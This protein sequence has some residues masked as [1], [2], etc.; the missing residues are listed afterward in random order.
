MRTQLLIIRLT[1]P[2]FCLTQISF[3]QDSA[4]QLVQAIRENRTEEVVRLVKNGS[5]VNEL[6]KIG[7]SPCINYTIVTNSEIY[8]DNFTINILG[9]NIPKICLT[10]CGPASAT[11]PITNIQNKTYDIE[12]KVGNNISTGR[13]YCKSNEFK[14]QMNNLIQTKIID[15]VLKR[16]PDDLI[17]GII[18]Y[19]RSITIDYAKKY[20]DLM[21]DWLQNKIIDKNLSDKVTTLNIS[22]FDFMANPDY[23]DLIIAEG[24]LNTVGFEKG[25]LRIVGILKKNRHVIIHDEFKDHEKKCDFIPVRNC[26][27]VDTIYLDEN[28]WWNDYY[29]KLESEIMAIDSKQ[30]R[31]LFKSDLEEV[32]CY[33]ADPGSFRSIYYLVEKL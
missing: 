22:F 20:G 10:A 33:R 21:D 12:F 9:I 32:K 28:I 1:I 19:H 18:G 7:I 16:V 2:L 11:I 3:T 25:F 8:E 13:L 4:D 5:S 24:F 31:D 29:R 15:P 23:Y 30:T 14:L 6:T 27:I 26:K 17:W